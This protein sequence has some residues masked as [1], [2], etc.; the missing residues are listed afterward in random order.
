VV[1]QV[2]RDFPGFEEDQFGVILDTFDDNR[3]GF[4]F[5]TNPRGAKSDAQVGGDGTSYNRNWDTIW[6]VRSKITDA[7]WQTEIAIPF[8]SLRFNPAESHT[9]GINFSRRIRRKNEE[10][11]WSPIPRPFGMSRISQAGRLE[12]MGGLRQGMNLQVKPY[13]SAPVVRLSDVEH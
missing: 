9:W 13:L 6:H 7:G 11:H 12:G 1:H 8:K 4:I 3:N 5:N 10:T 2:T